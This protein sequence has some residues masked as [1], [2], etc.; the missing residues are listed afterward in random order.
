MNIFDFKKMKS[1]ARKISM[2]TSYD[3]WS[4][5]LL[6]QTEV[7]C[8]LVGDSV[9]MVVHGFETTISA[10][11]EMMELHVAAVVRGAKNK[12]IIADMP[13]LAVNRGLEYAMNS[14]D[15][16]MKAG[17]HSIKIEGIRGHEDT[18]EKIILAGVPVMGH[19][20]LTP[21]SIH[22]LGG[23]RVQGRDEAAAAQLASDAKQLEN[24][25]CYALVLECIPA[26]L[27]TEITQSLSIP[28]IGIGAGQ[29]VDGQV[30]VLQDLL[31]LS[32]S[33]KPKFLRRFANGDEW[34]KS[35]CNQF[36][37]EVQNQTFPAPEE[38]YT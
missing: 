35:A 9:A 36:H 27:A 4:A 28:T 18:I 20:G 31:G 11:V 15:R 26:P 6:S 38:T 3:S 22:L 1:E 17:A 25:G 37:K 21:Q 2:V 5:R 33:F 34:L 23:N 13:F 12:W 30:L 16:L 8:L 7:D 14:V 24:L 19:L 10:T 29:Q 32:G